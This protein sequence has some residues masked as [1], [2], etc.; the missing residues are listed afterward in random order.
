MVTDEM[1]PHRFFLR[2]SAFQVFSTDT[3]SADKYSR[4]RPLLPIFPSSKD[5][6]RNKFHPVRR[7]LH[8][9]CDA[10]KREVIL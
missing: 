6:S 1:D 10:P 5:S 9:Q 3:L 2:P 8:E 7:T 4:E